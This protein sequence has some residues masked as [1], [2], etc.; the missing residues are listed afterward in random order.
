MIQQ[1]SDFFSHFKNSQAFVYS[2][3]WW[4]VRLLITF[5][6]YLSLFK[7]GT[8]QNL[9]I[10]WL[11]NCIFKYSS[12]IFF[13]NLFNDNFSDCIP[14]SDCKIMN[15][16]GSDCDLTEG[17]ILEFAC[18]HCCC[19]DWDSNWAPSEYK[20]K[21]LMLESTF[22]VNSPSTAMFSSLSYWSCCKI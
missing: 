2:A 10:L 11:A 18:Q 17:T 1:E 3:C 7:V 13:H 4:A 21:A 8:T 16:D 14:E 5:N 19:P 9:I 20:S 12:H 6:W 22:S 15:N